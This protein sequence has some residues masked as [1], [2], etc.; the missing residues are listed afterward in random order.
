MKKEVGAF[1]AKT[2]LPKLIEAVLRG[3]RITITRRGAPVAL[4][5]P[6][7]PAGKGD[8]QALIADFRKWRQGITWGE[9]MSTKKAR[10]EGRK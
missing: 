7:T 2:H 4:L 1:E 9:G 8:T 3:D 10:N 5:I 6:V